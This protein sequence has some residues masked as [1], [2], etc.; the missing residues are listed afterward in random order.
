VT[1]PC[2]VCGLDAELMP[3]P[4]RPVGAD[5]HPW[6]RLHRNRVGDWC[7]GTGLTADAPAP[8]TEDTA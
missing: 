7:P 6:V 8:S 4:R 3:D 5:G 1:G 2:P